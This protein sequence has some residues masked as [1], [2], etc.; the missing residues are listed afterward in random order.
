ML[1]DFFRVCKARRPHNQTLR[2]WILRLYG[3]RV[4]M[5][6][7]EFYLFGTNC[8][9]FC[10]DLLIISEFLFKFAAANGD[11]WQK[12]FIRYTTA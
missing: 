1:F 11:L 9:S 7:I 2:E 10:H 12:T 4:G 3:P 8:A 6:T 5:Y